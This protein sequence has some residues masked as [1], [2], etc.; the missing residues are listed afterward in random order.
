MNSETHIE[1][2]PLPTK[3]QIFH[4]EFAGISK[5]YLHLT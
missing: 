3:N 2:Q 4:I 1:K 5:K